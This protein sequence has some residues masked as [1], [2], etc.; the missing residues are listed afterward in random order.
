[1]FGRIKRLFRKQP[2]R[3]Q[4]RI[5]DL[6]HKLVPG[7]GEAETLQGELVRSIQNLADEGFRNGYINWSGKHEEYI[8]VL[9]LYLLDK[10][11]FDDRTLQ[12]LRSDL[13][14]VQQSGRTLQTE[15]ELTDLAYDSLR[16]I[17]EHVVQWCDAHPALIYRPR[18]QDFWLT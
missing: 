17:A 8:E 11:T 9:E 4:D 18:G 3:W 14:H 15:G 12:E 6:H 16:R 13:A 7:G 5:N 2:V 1:M 10:Q